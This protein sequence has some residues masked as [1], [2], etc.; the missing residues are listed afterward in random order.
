[1]LIASVLVHAVIVFGISFVMPSQAGNSD[2]S[3]PMK[4]IL[5]STPA[6]TAPENADALAQSN[7]V[8][9]AAAEEP[10]LI[11]LESQSRAKGE[12]RELER[13]LLE[14]QA[15]AWLN[16]EAEPPAEQGEAVSANERGA[17]VDSIDV[18]FLN[19]TSAPRELF[20][21]SS[22]R[23]SSL[24]PYLENWRLL[25]ERVGN[26][27]YPDA[28]KQQRLEGELILDVVVRSNGT[29]DSVRILRSSGHKVLDDG[30]KR[31][32]QIAGPFEPFSE[33]MVR[34]YDIL[35]IIRTWKFSADK[36]TD[37][38]R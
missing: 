5:V 29:V 9:E 28:A 7:S 32:V 2:F 36:V 16:P 22:A 19:A 11:A 10:P 3:P 20:V 17:L 27:N 15:D 18:A 26:I 12:T 1:V 31:I 37:I 38:T 14:E 6:D 23:M 35:H 34:D 4:I 30:A 33:E 13:I 24:A 25:V 21:R 8:G